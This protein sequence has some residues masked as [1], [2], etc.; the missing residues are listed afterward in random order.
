MGQLKADGIDIYHGLSGELPI[1]I[2]SVVTI[3]DL[4]F[5]RHPEF[6]NWIDVKMYTWKFRQTLKEADQIVAISE[7]TKRNVC[8]L[9]GVPAEKVTVVYQSCS[10]MFEPIK[11]QER[12]A[13]ARVKYNLPQRMI[14]SV[15]TI[16]QRK[17]CPAD[18]EGIAPPATRDGAGAGGAQHRLLRADPCLGR[19]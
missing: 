1:G 12:V 7:C 15:G 2:K 18:S 16:E 17:K 14:L 8:E 9:G 19:G 6:Y 3:H 10:T 13:Q 11:D 5:M 4:I